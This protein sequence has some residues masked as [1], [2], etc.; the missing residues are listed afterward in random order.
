MSLQIKTRTGTS[1]T[2]TS[3][4]P[5]LAQ[6]EIGTEYNTGKF[7]IGDGTTAWTGLSYQGS[8]GIT[9][10]APYKSMGDGSDGNVTISS[11]T[12]SLTRDMYYNNLTINST[13]IL[14]TNGWKVFVKGILDLSS[15]QAGA[16][17]WNGNNGGDASGSTGGS[18]P[19]AQPGGSLIGISGGGVGTTG[20]TATGTTGTTGATLNGSGGV[21]G[22]GGRGG[23]GNA[24]TSAGAAGGRTPGNPASFAIYE[25]NL[26]GIQVTPLG[27]GGGGGSGSAGSGDGST[28]TGGGSG[29]GGNGGGIIALYVNTLVKSNSTPAGVIQANGG[30]GGAGGNGSGSGAGGGGGG[31]GGAGGWIYL[32]YNRVYGPKIDSLIKSQGGDGGR[33]GSGSGGTNPAGATGGNGGSGGRITV[34]N[35]P[36]RTSSE[37]IPNSG[38]QANL[39][40]SVAFNTI[41]TGGTGGTGGMTKFDL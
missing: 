39:V 12:T 29:A 22:D 14:S 11:G 2:W 18:A 31:G 33:G 21:G 6:G 37:A 4:N 7:K 35:V 10:V 24:G 28:N 19:S 41:D 1:T 5:I 13:G 38:A 16:I 34:I 15:A 26:L 30:T 8:T 9:Q 25:T 23:F 36:L 3:T 17:Q 32:A 27:G 40:G 20:T